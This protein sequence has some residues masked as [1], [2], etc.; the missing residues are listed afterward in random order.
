MARRC[1]APPPNWAA[2]WHSVGRR[3]CKA[4]D[5]PGGPQRE[6]P[7]RAARTGSARWPKRL[8]RQRSWPAQPPRVVLLTRWGEPNRRNR[9]RNDPF[10]L[11]SNPS[12]EWVCYLDRE[13]ALSEREEG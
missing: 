7:G 3:P 5:S 13:Q 10:R 11:C 6:I 1:A 9:R 12:E 8:P 2:T 4:W